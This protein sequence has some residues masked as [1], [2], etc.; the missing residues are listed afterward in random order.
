[1]MR[2]WLPRRPSPTF[3]D[4]GTPLGDPFEAP[5]RAAAERIAIFRYGR[6]VVVELLARAGAHIASEVEETR[7]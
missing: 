6:P 3:R 4:L 5:D 1:M 2:R 7:R